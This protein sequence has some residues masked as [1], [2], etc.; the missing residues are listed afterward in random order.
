M[1][2]FI[3]YAPTKV[4]FGRGAE[5]ETAGQLKAFGAGKVLL[6]FGGGSAVRSGLIGRLKDQLSGAGIPFTVLGG[7]RPNPRLSLVYE[8]IRLCREEG[9]DFI[10]SVGGGSAIDSGKLIAAGVCYDGDVLDIV[11]KKVPYT[12]ALPHACVV[13]IAATGSEMSDSA[14]ITVDTDGSFLKRG[15][16]HSELNRPRFAI[17]DPE[18]TYTLPPYQT[19]SGAVDIIMHTNERFFSPGGVNELSDRIAAS[20]IRTV[21]DY[22]PICLAEP[23]NY[24]ARSEIMWAASLS[25]N[26]LTGLGRAGDWAS[27]QL[28]HALGG[29]YDVAHGAGLAAVWGSWARYVLEGNEARF[30]R[31]A[32]DVFE[33]DV[34]ITNPKKAALAGIEAA[35][36][37][38]RSIGMPVTIKELIGHVPD[39]AEIKRLVH[40]C[41]YY[42]KRSIGT[43]R[44]LD[45]SDMYRIFRM[46]AE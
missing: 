44:K 38:F 4:I 41:S 17:M 1:N 42:G 46:A 14:V 25:H 37:F 36:S 22:T 11:S 26:D 32:H 40:E 43:L 10:L 13:T 45:E 16:P 33:I 19:A 20:L 35:E 30:A 8:G 29:V 9:V 12:A 18:L 21:V 2:S 7:A 24:D 6:H 5:K 28:E 15:A 27:H 34:D 23:D 31:Y 3:Y 39:E